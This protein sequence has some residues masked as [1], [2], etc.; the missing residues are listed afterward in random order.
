MVCRPSSA[1]SCFARRWRLSGQKRV[2]R[3]PATMTG[4]KFIFAKGYKRLQNENPNLKST[5]FNLKFLLH[6]G[7]WLRHYR[8]GYRRLDKLHRP[9][10]PQ[11]K[12]AN[13]RGHYYGVASSQ[14]HRVCSRGFDDATA[15]DRYQNLNR[16]LAGLVVGPELVRFFEF[17]H[18]DHEVRRGDQRRPAIG[19]AV[20]V[21]RRRTNHLSRSSFL[22][23]GGQAFLQ[24]QLARAPVVV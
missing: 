2:P 13:G 6:P 8:S 20:Q 7:F 24:M 10:W 11:L 18:F 15:L 22:L 1:S 5:I 23:Y 14:R 16:T 4:W 12:F 19:G 9:L 17:E 3:P 21:G